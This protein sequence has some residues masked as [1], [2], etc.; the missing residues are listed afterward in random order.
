ME[1]GWFWIWLVSAAALSFAGWLALRERARRRSL[2]AEFDR[3]RE[4]VEPIRQRAEELHRK[5]DQLAASDMS[6]NELLAIVGHDLKN[7][8][9]VVVGCAD[10]LIKHTEADSNNG[11]YARMIFQSASQMQEMLT[12]VQKISHLDR[13]KIRLEN[14]RLDLAA[15]VRDSVA[16]HRAAAE[17]K[18][19]SLS[20]STEADCFAGGDAEFVRDV[21]DNLVSNAVKFSPPGKPIQVR[22]AGR[23]DCVRLEVEDKGPGLPAEEKAQLFHK[24]RRFS[25]IP[26]SGE[27]SYGL[28]LFLDRKIVD[29]LGGRIGAETSPGR[30]STF[31]MELPRA[32][33][34]PRAHLSDDGTHSRP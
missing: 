28:G 1:N 21:V 25:A 33:D 32:G 34:R 26:T 19:Q 14:A 29:H 17:R 16:A 4:Q 22:V 24:V 27:S 6:K 7:P 31:W 15:L 8:L 9:T 13:G 11:R 2:Q 3:L 23:E 12:E 10:L 5:A 20:L 30:G 18:N